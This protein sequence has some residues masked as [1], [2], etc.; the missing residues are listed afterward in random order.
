M[1][2]RI[3]PVEPGQPIS[4]RE[5]AV[6]AQAAEGLSNAE[7]GRVLFIARDTVKSHLWTASVKLGAR[8]RAHAVALSV[9]MGL[10]VLP[11]IR[12]GLSKKE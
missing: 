10:I 8:N 11:P 1:T 4:S 3:R 2:A 9:R 5:L 7:I 6:I 12:P